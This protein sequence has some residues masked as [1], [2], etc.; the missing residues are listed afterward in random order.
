MF[1]EICYSV[2]YVE[3]HGRPKPEDPWSFRKYAV[4]QRYDHEKRMSAWILIQPRDT[5]RAYLEARPMSQG[6]DNLWGPLF[7]H[8]RFLKSSSIA[9]RWLLNYLSDESNKMVSKVRSL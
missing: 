6:V 7:I 9:W 5:A 1:R 3:R 2:Q 4:Y 8:L